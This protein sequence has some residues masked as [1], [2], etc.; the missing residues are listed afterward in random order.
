MEDTYSQLNRN[1]STLNSDKTL[2]LQERPSQP[3]RGRRFE[4]LGSDFSQTRAAAAGK[5]QGG[6]IVSLKEMINQ[7]TLTP[8]DVRNH[9][10]KALAGTI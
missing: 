9:S 1:K 7:L 10:Q 8:E 5:R 2:R 4:D 6:S 3:K